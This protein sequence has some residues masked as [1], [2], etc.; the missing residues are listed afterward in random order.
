MLVVINNETGLTHEFNLPQ[1]QGT[2]KQIAWAESIRT[3]MLNHFYIRFSPKFKTV[4]NMQLILNN[5]SLASWWIDN[6]NH[7]I[8]EI[9]NRFSEIKDYGKFHGCSGIVSVEEV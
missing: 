1:L 5:L 4:E 2:E 9:E 7:S 8:R 3:D 6:R